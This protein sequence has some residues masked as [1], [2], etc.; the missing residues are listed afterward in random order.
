MATK[1]AA[2]LRRCSTFGNAWFL[3]DAPIHAARNARRVWQ[4]EAPSTIADSKDKRGS[5]LT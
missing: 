1:E 5:R 4:I 3:G 2:S